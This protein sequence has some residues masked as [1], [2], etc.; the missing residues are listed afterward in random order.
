MFANV[1]FVLRRGPIAAF[2]NQR[3]T[4]PYVVGGT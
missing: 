2:G 4:N 1:Q 3:Q